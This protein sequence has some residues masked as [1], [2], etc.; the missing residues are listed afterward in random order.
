[1]YRQLAAM[2][3]VNHIDSSGVNPEVLWEHPDP[4]STTFW[5]FKD[6]I[7]KK[8]NV[9]FGP[10]TSENSLWR[11]YINNIQEFWEE[12]WDFTGIKASRKFDKVVYT[13]LPFPRSY[14]Y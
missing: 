3:D 9:E 1:E 8:Y 13:S 14:H 2:A 10:E 7:S 4:Q 5:R 6:A 12:V 11:W